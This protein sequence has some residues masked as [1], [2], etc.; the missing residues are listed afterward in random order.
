MRTYALLI[1]DDEASFR[2]L[3]RSRLT[4]KGYAVTA[5][6]D[7]TAA[8]GALAAEE[9]DA[10]IF[11]LR[12]PGAGGLE[13][14]RRARELQ[15]ALPVLILTGHGSIETAI[16]AIRAGAYDYLTKPC[17]LAELEL[18]VTKA[19]ERK[20]LEVENQGLREALRRQ[21]GQAEIVGQSRALTRLLQM[22]ERVAASDTA[23]LVEGESGTGKELI[24]RAVHA[25]SPRAAGPFIPVNCGAL[26]D[27]L[28]ESEL[29][30]YARGAFTGAVTTKLGLVELAEGGTLFLDEIGELPLELQAKLLRFLESHE[31]RRVG[32]T[33][34]RR[35]DARVVAATNRH[36]ADEVKAGRFREDLFYRLNVVALVVPPLRERRED[37]P[38]LVAH[39]LAG[40]DSDKELTPE[41]M[42]ALVRYDFPGNIRELFNLVRRGAILSPDRFIAPEDLGMTSAE[43]QPSPAA[44]AVAPSAPGEPAILTLVE[45]ERRTIAAALDHTDWNRAQAAQVLGI[46]VRNL[47]RKI[48]A[49]DLHPRG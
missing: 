20:A 4:R 44:E 31:L 8:L 10:A 22:T 6:A 33:R 18:I 29:F 39:F 28:L 37:I 16:E 36:L 35:V 21:G 32:E 3:L 34:L 1:A 30:G 17:N 48:E 24:A 49:Y 13:V 2:E 41:A 23:V 19:L 12:M 26:P 45:T 27:N 7:G 40:T 47:Y 15:P 46:S 43:P 5:V 42:E 25:L 11:D 9:Y 38:L 14:L